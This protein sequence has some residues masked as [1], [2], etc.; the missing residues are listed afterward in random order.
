MKKILTIIVLFWA[1]QPAILSQTDF[2]NDNVQY[3]TLYPADLRKFLQ[4][5]PTYVLID[6]RSPGEFADTSRFGNL[7]QGRI[8]GAINIPIDSIDKNMD[9]L[10]SYMGQPIVLYC[11]H[12][13]RSRRVGKKLSENGFKQLY[14]L[15]GGM[16]WMNQAN[17]KCFPGKEDL[18]TTNLP[19][20]LISVTDAFSLY[21]K[22]KELVIV[23]IRSAVQFNC[24][25]TIEANNLGR[26]RNSINLAE[27]DGKIDL[28]KLLEHKSKKLLIY[29]LYGQKSGIVSKYL[30]ENGFQRVYNLMGGLNA[31]YVNTES[32]SK[33]RKSFLENE[34][35][36]KII[37]AKESLKLITSSKNIIVLDVRTPEEYNNKSKELWRNIGRIKNSKNL[38]PNISSITA[39]AIPA[40]KK[41]LI[42]IC[43]SDYKAYYFS[44]LLRE[45]GYTNIY[46][47]SNGIW[48]LVYS[49]SN[50]P[51]FELVVE[52]FENHTDMF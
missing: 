5:N 47:L 8:I 22:N 6:V 30:I 32:G 1:H 13:Q 20:Q 16:T 27:K 2:I 37:G 10:K 28:E 4:E 24:K 34:P 18:L 19:Y 50:I 36:Y 29:D 15:N 21:K 40:D 14:N 39:P 44:K 33:Y 42:F 17:E 52:I 12:S 9:K 11:S 7:N 26:L 3:K 23:D 51:G 45:Q 48:S 31:V 41:S 46:C 38:L 25:D 35:N 49:H 43:G